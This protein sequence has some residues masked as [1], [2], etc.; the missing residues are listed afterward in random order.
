MSICVIQ[1]VSNS[2]FTVETT[3]LELANLIV[4]GY[5]GSR[6]EMAVICLKMQGG[7]QLNSTTIKVGNRKVRFKN[8]CSFVELIV[9]LVMAILGCQPH[10][11]W[12]GTGDTH[13]EYFS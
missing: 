12:N 3:D 9:S 13:E 6:D 5:E 8:T 4:I 11:I 2:E 7:S 1:F 10:C